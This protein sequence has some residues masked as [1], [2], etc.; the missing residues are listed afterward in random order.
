MSDPTEGSAARDARRSD[1]LQVPAIQLRVMRASDI[2]AG[3]RL[4]RASHWNQL[5]RD[6]ELFLAL[7][8]DGCRVAVEETGEVVGSVAAVRYGSAFGWIAM[9]LVD[10]AYRGN[11]IGAQLLHAALDILA[12]VA[13]VRLDATP[14]GHRVYT[15]FGFV[16]EYTIHRMQR[17][18][19]PLAMDSPA[20]QQLL[21]TLAQG[22]PIRLMEDRDLPQVFAQDE[23]V[24]GADRRALLE[25]FR[26]QAPEYAWVCGDGRIDGY[27]FGR[28]GYAFQHLGPLVA[29][30]EATAR[31]LL[32]ACL[33]ASADRAFIVD[34]P[35]RP[36]MSEFLE[37]LHFTLQRPFTRMYRGQPCRHERT[38]RV[39]AIAGPEFA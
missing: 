20:V 12:D 29:R 13:T 38:D 33:T 5:A 11:G 19:Q 6:W 3:L 23:D 30:D 17:V 8:P 24:F 22:P 18:A 31:R 34:V 10:P 35:A 32:G 4:T 1:A 2:P 28:R 37:S 14:A 7:S 39:F 15:R 25:V 26:D 21:A 16:D 9:V 27:L 36:H